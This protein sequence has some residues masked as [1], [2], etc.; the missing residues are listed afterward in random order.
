MRPPVGPIN[1]IM[2]LSNQKRTNKHK[3]Y[4]LGRN[5]IYYAGIL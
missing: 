3:G 4:N 1:D 2:A 5:Y